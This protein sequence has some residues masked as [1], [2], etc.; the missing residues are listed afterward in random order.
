MGGVLPLNFTCFRITVQANALRATCL[1]SKQYHFAAVGNLY[2]R[3][4]LQPQFPREK[5][6]ET[7]PGKTPPQLIKCVW[8]AQR[9]EISNLIKTH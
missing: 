5:L 8:L 9:P 6:V 1:I 3:G 2:A 4:N 7:A